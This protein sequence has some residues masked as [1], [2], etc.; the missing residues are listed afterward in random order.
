MPPDFGETVYRNCRGKV[1]KYA[2]TAG[3]LTTLPIGCSRDPGVPGVPRVP[4]VPSG[5]DWDGF[6]VEQMCL[7]V[8]GVGSF[9]AVVCYKIL[10]GMDIRTFNMLE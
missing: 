3:W 9:G 2:C 6:G 5:V 10:C 8:A 7:F 1:N 4:R